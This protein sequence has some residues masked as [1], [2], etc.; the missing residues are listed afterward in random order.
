MITGRRIALVL[1]AVLVVLGGLA[2]LG[3]WATHDWQV[4][5]IWYK[6]MKAPNQYVFDEIPEFLLRTDPARLI[7]D[8][9][10]QEIAP[11]KTR[12]NTVLWGAPDLP[13]RL[14]ASVDSGKE[15][16]ALREIDEADRLERLVIPFELGYTAYAYLLHPETPNGRAVIY[17]HGYAGKVDQSSPLLET[18]L[19]QGY[20]VAAINYAGYGQNLLGMIDHPD[21]GFVN[22]GN[23]RQMHYVTHPLRWYLEPMVVTVNHLQQSGISD[24]SSIGFSAGGWVT[25]MVAA[26]DTRIRSTV[27]VASGYPMYIRSANWAV[28]S[29]LPQMYKPLL[30][31]AS[32]LETYVL[33]ALGQGR[34]YIQIF[35]QYDRCCYRNRFAELYAPAVSEAVARLGD[36]RFTALIDVSHAEHMVSPW[37]TSEI[38]TILSE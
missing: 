32:Y 10:P 37:A 20:L 26:V 19:Q 34:Q 3:Y 8:L 4:G 18:L 25:T 7:A 12:L 2:G 9:T 11:L 28:E 35:N 15:P 14:P 13:E 36:G 17:H 22:A 33:A 5:R 38:L 24:I 23:D 30:D 27:A 31:T 1:I 6:R 29:P 21:F 16:T